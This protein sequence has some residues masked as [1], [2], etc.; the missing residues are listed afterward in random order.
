MPRSAYAFATWEGKKKI[1]T[2]SCGQ[3][4]HFKIS[5]SALWIAGSCLQFSGLIKERDP[6]TYYSFL[7]LLFFSSQVSFWMLFHT[8]FFFQRTHS[9]PRFFTSTTSSKPLYHFST[10]LKSQCYWTYRWSVI[11]GVKDTAARFVN[12]S[13]LLEDLTGL[14][15]YLFTLDDWE[16]RSDMM[17]TNQKTC[18][19]H[20]VA[21]RCLMFLKS[22]MNR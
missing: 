3:K 17:V 9:R 2:I 8:F 7:A 1:A 5:V 11:L 18:L 10:M 22:E 20:V 19:W 12:E 14:Q 6:N 21:S 16:A 13:K 4:C 15:K